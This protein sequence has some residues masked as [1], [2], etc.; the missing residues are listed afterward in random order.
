MNTIKPQP[1]AYL[2]RIDRRTWGAFTT[3]SD[4][5]LCHGPK[6]L[7]RD[8]AEEYGFEIISSAL[9]LRRS[10][11]AISLCSLQQYLAVTCR[12]TSFIP[13]CKHHRDPDTF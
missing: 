4:T 3:R 13:Q 8:A 6:Q 1:T 12:L 10:F 2:R 9:F 5:L 11:F 7:C